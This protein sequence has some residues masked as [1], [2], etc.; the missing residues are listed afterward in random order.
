MGFDPIMKQASSKN[1][2]LLA[3]NSSYTEYAEYVASI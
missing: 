3:A 2:I 1:C